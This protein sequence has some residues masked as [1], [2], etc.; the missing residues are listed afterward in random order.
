MGLSVAKGLLIERDFRMPRTRQWL[1]VLVF[2]TRRNMRRFARRGFDFGEPPVGCPAFCT[3]LETTVYDFIGDGDGACRTKVDPRYFAVIFLTAGGLR[4]DII[5]HEAVH[6]A[7]SFRRRRP[8]FPWPDNGNPEET[9][10]YP[11]GIIAGMIH[12]TIQGMQ[13]RP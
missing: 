1:K 3:P 12:E 9:L 7:F 2:D 5:T 10:C 8:D 4:A 11:A 6:A 13:R